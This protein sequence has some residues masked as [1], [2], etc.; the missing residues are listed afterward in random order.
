MEKRRSSN[1]KKAARKAPKKVAA[2]AAKKSR[3]EK[4]AK[5]T[6]AKKP[7]AKKTAAKRPVARK[8]AGKVAPKPVVPP[9]KAKP[10]KRPAFNEKTDS[11]NDPNWI[12]PVWNDDILL[13]A[14]V[15]SAGGTHNAPP[16]ARAIGATAMQLFTKMANRWAERTCE[17]DECTL[18]RAAVGETGVRATMAHDSYL[19]NLASPDALLRRRSIESFVSE[20]QRCAS[21]GL[22]YLVSHPGNYIDDRASGIQRNADAITEALSRAPGDTI[23]CMETTAGSGTAI[24]ATFDDLAE[25]FAL[26]PEPYKQRLG[27]CVDSCHAYSAGYD[28][29]NAYDDVWQT[30]DD[31]LGMSRLKVM[32]LNDSKTPFN[33][34]RD[35]HELIGE[36]SLGEKAF[37]HIMNDERL[38]SVPKVIETPKGT[39]PTATDARMLAR[40]RGYI[41]AQ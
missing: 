8:A 20:L 30:F 25:L 34:R 17:G 11:A 18:F 14:H 9:E 36:G 38:K 1:K 32:H 23:L 19:I 2:K 10:A 35:R 26:V 12:P 28:F 31:L 40:L 15:S 22:T 29:V 24:G 5:K 7:V 33:S 3:L 39:D 21:L 41:L 13:G 27:V 4:P 37:R 6:A 16:R